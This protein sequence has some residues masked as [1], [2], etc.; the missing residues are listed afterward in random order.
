MSSVECQIEDEINKTLLR[1][2]VL[3]EETRNIFEMRKKHAD[4]SSEAQEIEKLRNALQKEM[5][6][7]KSVIATSIKRF[8]Y[9]SDLLKTIVVND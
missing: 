2:Y 8:T 9:C 5:E 7:L 4:A 6:Q 1:S 3:K